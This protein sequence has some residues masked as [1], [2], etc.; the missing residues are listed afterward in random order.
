VAIN[1]RKDKQLVVRVTPAVRSS[2][3]K[4]SQKHGGTSAVL[5]EL[6]EAFTQDRVSITPPPMKEI[7]K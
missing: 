3:V 5:R 2:F 7:Y 4:S 1:N 6:V